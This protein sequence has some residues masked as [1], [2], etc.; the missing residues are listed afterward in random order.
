[1][2]TVRDYEC[3]L[4]IVH[5]PG[6]QAL[7]DFT[8]IRSLIAARA[9]EMEVFILA[10]RA[11]NSVSRK[12]AAGRRTL[13][14]SPVLIEQF[15]PIRGK[16]YMCRRLGKLE[17]IRRLAAAGLRVP[18]TIL[19]EPD[20]RLDPAVWGPFTVVKPNAGKQ[21]GG[22]RLRRTHDVRW[23]EP[24]SLSVDDP[25][26]D[27]PILAQKFVDT[28]PLS[29]SFRVFTVFGRPVYSLASQ[30]LTARPFIS[31]EG[32]GPVDLAIASNAGERQVELNF[33]PEIIEF[34]ASA[35]RAFQE[36]PVLGIDVIRE[37]ATGILY[38]LEVN[39]AGYTWHFSSDY[40]QALL[41]NYNIDL[42]AQFG[43]L[44]IIADA[45]IE[46]TRREAE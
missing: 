25:H 23:R 22:V 30:S 17:E 14:F 28:G 41:K 6:L 3:N 18:E 11:R 40:G 21:G 24:K 7:A 42:A 10:N 27:Q 35:C 29:R 45:L 37:A 1:L 26:Y 12:S 8:T 43:A 39:S 33:D 31:P 16:V 4:V 32:I 44:D 20:T 9:P 5:T 13:V 2:G 46:V 34:G 38:I 15:S 36:I 19:L